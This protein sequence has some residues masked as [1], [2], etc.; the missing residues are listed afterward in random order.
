VVL[1]LLKLPSREVIHEINGQLQK[2]T[3]EQH[4]ANI[5]LEERNAKLAEH[6]NI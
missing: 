4:L 5:S 6:I 1:Q 2:L 3:W